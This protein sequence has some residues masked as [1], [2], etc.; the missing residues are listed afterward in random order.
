LKF[1][2]EKTH[3]REEISIFMKLPWKP[4]LGALIKKII[5]T[6]WFVPLVLTLLT[7]LFIFLGSYTSIQSQVGF[8]LF[9]AGML[10]IGIPH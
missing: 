8:I 5:S 4:F 3:L 2:D 1:L 6:S 9:A 10:T 7:L